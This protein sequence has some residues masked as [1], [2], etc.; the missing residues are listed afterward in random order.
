M[1][2]TIIKYRGRSAR[3]RRAEISNN[4][5]ILPPPLPPS[6]GRRASVRHARPPWLL[7]FAKE[8]PHKGPSI[9]DVHP[10]KGGGQKITQICGQTIHN[11]CGQMGGRGS[12]NPKKFC[13]RH[14]WI[15]TCQKR[16]GCVNSPLQR[17]PGVIH[18]TFTYFCFNSSFNQ[19]MFS[20]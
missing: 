12:E 20:L 17:E 2:L 16:L 19:G 7:C 14:L 8:D 1:F 11:L 18:A 10:Q 5:D 6:R 3:E 13:G 4:R 15:Q 9:Y